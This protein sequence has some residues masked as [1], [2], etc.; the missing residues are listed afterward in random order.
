MVALKELITQELE[1]LNEEQLRQVADFLAF[2][3]FRSRSRRWKIDESQMAAFYSEFAEEDQ[4]YIN[5]SYQHNSGRATF[6]P[7]FTPGS[8]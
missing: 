3:K 5:K 7:I 8:R 1:T 6:P 4:S 2:L